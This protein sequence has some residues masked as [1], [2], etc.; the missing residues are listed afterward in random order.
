MEMT[1]IDTQAPP[2][3]LGED[4]SIGLYVVFKGHVASGGTK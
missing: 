3:N 2:Y 4:E 1:K